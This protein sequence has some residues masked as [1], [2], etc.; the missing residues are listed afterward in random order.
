ML[1]KIETYKNGHL[2]VVNLLSGSK[3]QVSER[4]RVVGLESGDIFEGRL[5]PY[6]NV[7]IFTD[8]FAF[9]PREARRAISKAAKAFKKA[10][11][12]DDLDEGRIDFVHRVAYLANRSQRYKHVDPKQI[13]IDL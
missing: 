1:P 4:R 7:C 2:H 10:H 8:T 12:P 5:V 6:D 3:L 11:G 9:H 13:F